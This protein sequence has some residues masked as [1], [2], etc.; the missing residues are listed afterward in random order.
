MKHLSDRYL[1][2]HGETADVLEA[3]RWFGLSWAKKG[4][5]FHLQYLLNQNGDPIAQE[6]LARQELAKILSLYFRIE[7]GEQ[8]AVLELAERYRETGKLGHATALL[9]AAERQG[10]KDAA[11]RLAEIEPKLS[12][13][14]KVFANDPTFFPFIQ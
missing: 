2:G 7:R 11:K 13:E 4:Y 5:A 8:Q 14:E 1:L 6:S 12:P 10:S 3:A 9:R